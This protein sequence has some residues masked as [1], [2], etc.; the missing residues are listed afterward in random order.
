MPRLDKKNSAPLYDQ[1]VIQLISYIEENLVSGDKLL[2]ERE[3]CNLYSVS[4]TTVRQALSE[5]EKM[6]YIYKHQGKG[7][8]V[9]TLRDKRSDLTDSYS[10]SDHM[11]ELGHSPKTEILSFERVAANYLIAEQMQLQPG[12]E[13]FRFHRLRSADGIAMMYETTH[14]PVYQFSDM[15]IDLLNSMPLYRLFAGHYDVHIKYADEEFSASL[16]SEREARL[17]NSHTNAPCLRIVRICYQANGSI[18]EYT[19][20]VARADQFVYR[21]RHYSHK[22]PKTGTTTGR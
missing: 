13:V 5:L 12:E 6:G 15:D 19:T 7:T 4:R 3:I 16:M 8:F 14:V 9:S 20:S 21:V 1:L 2:S 22:P 11:R 10:F 17:L 18:I